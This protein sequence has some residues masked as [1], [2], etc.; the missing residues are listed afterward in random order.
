[1]KRRPSEMSVLEII[2]LMDGPICSVAMR[3]R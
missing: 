2:E 3:S 1:L